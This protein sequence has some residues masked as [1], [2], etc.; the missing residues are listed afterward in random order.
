MK[1]ENNVQVTFKK[2]GK[3]RQMKK[4]SQQAK[5]KIKQHTLSD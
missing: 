2:M 4:E 3:M 5:Q 1:L